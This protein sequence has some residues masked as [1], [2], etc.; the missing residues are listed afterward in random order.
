[1][2]SARITASRLLALLMLAGL[3]LSAAARGETGPWTTTVIKAPPAPRAPVIAPA[4]QPPAVEQTAGIVSIVVQPRTIGDRVRT[5]LGPLGVILVFLA[6]CALRG[7]KRAK[8]SANGQVA[9]VEG[10]DLARGSAQLVSDAVQPEAGVKGPGNEAALQAHDGAQVGPERASVPTQKK[11]LLR[12]IVMGLGPIVWG[13]GATV[14]L[15]PL[16]RNFFYP[17]AAQFMAPKY[18][19]WVGITAHML[20]CLMAAF[21]MTAA[22]GRLLGVAPA[23]RAPGFS[24]FRL[25][26]SLLRGLLWCSTLMWDLVMS[27]AWCIRAALWI[28]LGMVCLSVKANSTAVTVGRLLGLDIEKMVEG[29][30]MAGWIAIGWGAVIVLAKAVAPLPKYFGGLSA[31]G[32]RA[33]PR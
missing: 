17:A 30:V 3:A 11:A 31:Q 25:V 32:S 23:R 19:L 5:W 33:A 28:G 24:V 18:A 21:L 4:Q 26:G 2:A 14:V 6:S 12:S 27:V 8:R 15:R 13:Y 9:A 22:V 10:Q 20:V 16:F 29:I 1:M 7:R